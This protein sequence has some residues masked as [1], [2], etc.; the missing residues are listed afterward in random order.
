M[1]SESSFGDG[2]LSTHA[3]CRSLNLQPHQCTAEP[4]PSVLLFKHC[5]PTELEVISHAGLTGPA[6][7][8]RFAS[9]V[10]CLL[11]ALL[12]TRG[13][14]CRMLFDSFMSVSVRPGQKNRWSEVIHYLPNRYACSGVCATMYPSSMHAV[15]C[16][17]SVQACVHACMHACNAP[18]PELGTMFCYRFHDCASVIASTMNSQGHSHICA[19]HLAGSYPASAWVDSFYRKTK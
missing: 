5:I 14:P 3:R 16:D 10:H 2:A 19:Q 15:F 8:V 18:L 6:F 13:V 4:I 11:H 9:R 12:Q 1:L 17:H 7:E